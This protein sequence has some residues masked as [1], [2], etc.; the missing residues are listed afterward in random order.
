MLYTGQ[1][2]LAR[3]LLERSRDRVARQIEPDGRQPRE[4]ERTR[5]WD[6]S[7]FNLRAFLQLARLGERLGLDLWDYRS[8]DGRSLRGARHRHHRNPWIVGPPR[9]NPPAHGIRGV[10]AC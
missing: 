8:S 10:D 4:L 2:E 5:S 9:R 1:H 3:R 7:I 6:Y